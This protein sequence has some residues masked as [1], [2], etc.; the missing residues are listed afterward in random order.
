MEPWYEQREGEAVVNSVAAEAYWMWWWWIWRGGLMMWLRR[1]GLQ[2]HSCL[3]VRESS[4]TEIDDGERLWQGAGGA[5]NRIVQQRTTGWTVNAVSVC[6]CLLFLPITLC[7]DTKLHPFQ[8]LDNQ[9]LKRHGAGADGG[10]AYRRAVE[11]NLPSYERQQKFFLCS[12]WY[13]H[14]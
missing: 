7:R 6:L 13:G 4:G 14:H 12:D 9:P 8:F 5:G 1:C 2:W 10:N 3:N 11:F